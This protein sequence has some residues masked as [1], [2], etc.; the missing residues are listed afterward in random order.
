MVLLARPI[1]PTMAFRC[2]TG[3]T[4]EDRIPRDRHQSAHAPV[5]V[6]GLM[7]IGL[8][9]GSGNSPIE[10]GWSGDIRSRA[11]TTL[12]LPSSHESHARSAD[13]CSSRASTSA[14]YGVR[15]TG[16]STRL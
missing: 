14:W 15:T 10:D 6:A 12:S 13:D 8:R 9:G 2:R 16:L 4:M 1:V 11:T 3:T 5:R 7:V